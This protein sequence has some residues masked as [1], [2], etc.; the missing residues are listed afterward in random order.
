[1]I[2]FFSVTEYTWIFSSKFAV[3]LIGCS[4][5]AQSRVVVGKTAYGHKALQSQVLP[6]PLKEAGGVNPISW[7][8]VTIHVAH[9]TLK[10]NLVASADR[11]AVE[12]GP[13]YSKGKG[14]VRDVLESSLLC[15]IS[16][17]ALNNPVFSP[18]L[19]QSPFAALPNSWS[20]FFC[21]W[22]ISTL[23]FSL[24][25]T[26]RCI[27]AASSK[28]NCAACPGPFGFGLG[29]SLPSQCAFVSRCLQRWGGIQVSFISVQVQ[30]FT[31]RMSICAKGGEWTL[32]SPGLQ[33]AQCS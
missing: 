22:H 30:P 28:Y 26:T 7:K 27:S 9:W 25:T 12:R 19:L 5:C 1:M 2:N 8:I 16:Y 18:T 21:C 11:L 3:Q 24:F 33:L 15:L 31:G 10:T 23:P 20:P 14:D 32:L 4:A 29:P 17:S 6:R 13:K